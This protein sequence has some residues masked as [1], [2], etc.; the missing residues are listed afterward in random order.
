MV[1]I[2]EF[3]DKGDLVI[4]WSGT[5]GVRVIVGLLEVVVICAGAQRPTKLIT[6]LIIHTGNKAAVVGW[7]G[8]ADFEKPEEEKDDDLEDGREHDC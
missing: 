4:R 2:V 3:V 1:V 8:K 6:R 5:D 7:K